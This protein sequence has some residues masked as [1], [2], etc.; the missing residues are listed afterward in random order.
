MKI[1]KCLHGRCENPVYNAETHCPKHVV[2]GPAMTPQAKPKR[3]PDV[4]VK[5]DPPYPIGVSTTRF[6]PRNP[7][8]TEHR[9]TPAKPRKAQVCVWTEDFNAGPEWSLE[10]IHRISCD[11]ERTTG[12]PRG[13]FCPHCGGKIKV[14]S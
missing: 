4:W 12:T 14:K 13:K 6:R 8:I 11:S 10:E 5:F 2:R 3:L 7:G 1:G 9:Y